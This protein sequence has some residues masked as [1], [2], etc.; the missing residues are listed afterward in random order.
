V[1]LEASHKRYC[2]AHFTIGHEIGHFVL[3]CALG[4]MSYA[5]TS[6]PKKRKPFENP[7]WQANTFASELLM[8]YEE[9]LSL[10]PK[11]IKRKYHVTLSAATTRYN[12]IHQS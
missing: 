12:K 7:E 8:P 9:C 11:E 3:H 5:R 2:R 10:S 1:F 6:S 4:L